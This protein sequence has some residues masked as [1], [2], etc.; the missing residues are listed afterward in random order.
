MEEEPK[1]KTLLALESEDGKDSEGITW[2]NL[3]GHATKSLSNHN[4]EKRWGHHCMSMNTTTNTNEDHEESCKCPII[5]KKLKSCWIKEVIVY[6]SCF[7][8]F[9]FNQ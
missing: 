9:T 7:I 1:T 2:K 4:I 5:C 3:M 8:I 6:W